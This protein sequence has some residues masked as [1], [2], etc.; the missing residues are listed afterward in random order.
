M[1]P[2]MSPVFKSRS[3]R[4]I[5]SFADL[6]SAAIKGT[7]SRRPSSTNVQHLRVFTTS[8]LFPGT[9]N[10]PTDSIAPGPPPRNMPHL[11]GE[12]SD[13]RLGGD[14]GEARCRSERTSQP[15]KFG[16]VT[17]PI[18]PPRPSRNCPEWLDA[19]KCEEPFA[20][21]C[22]NEIAPSGNPTPA[23]HAGPGWLLRGQT[24]RVRVGLSTH[25]RWT[26]QMNR[27]VRLGVGVMPVLLAVAGFLMLPGIC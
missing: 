1:A 11:P 22:R 23:W 10:R 5:A 4:F 9:A 19:V 25:K 7:V 20:P 17:A 26:P 13:G 15:G 3:P 2:S 12:S 24:M 27:L 8:P 18:G 6:N 14:G 16:A 21:K